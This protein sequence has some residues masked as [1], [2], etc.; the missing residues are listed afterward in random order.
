[1]TSPATMPALAAGPFGCGSATSAPSAFFRPRLSAISGVTGWICTPIQPRVTVP[2]S[3]SWATTR[4]TVLGGNGESDADRAARRRKDR[5][6]DA[7]DIAIDIE[8]RA[9]GIAFVDRRIDLDEIVIR[10]GADV[11]ATGGH[12]AGGDGAP[13]TEG[14]A[15]RDHPIA[16]AR[17]RDRQTSRRGS[18]AAVDLD[19]RE[20]GARSVPMTLAV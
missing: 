6:V 4:F 17:R 7:D 5:R 10:A 8:G 3:L 18:L 13:E 20:I 9:A 15:D 14:I 1:M 12:D 2:L 11:A 16:D 19:Q